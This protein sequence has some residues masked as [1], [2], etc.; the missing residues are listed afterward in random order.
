MAVSSRE[1]YIDGKRV[2][3]APA[4]L[5]GQGGEAEVY[6]LGDG[7]VLKWWKPV[8]H[9]DF[10]GLPDAQAA[11]ARRLAEQ[12]AKLRALPGNL[13]AAVVT[14]CGLALDRKQAVVGY[15]MTKVTGEPLHAYGEPRWRRDHAI[16]G[17]DVVAILVAL[18]DALAGLHRAGVVVGDCN[19]L[20]V[21]VDGNRVH[22]IDVDSYQYGG[23][24]CP[25][26]SE[27]FL[28][29]RLVAANGA[30]APHDRDSDWFAF[31]VMTLR[32][33]L[34]VGP[35]GG[36][37]QPSNPT[38]R[39]PPPARAQRRISVFAPDIIYPRAARPVA[40][41][42][43]AMLEPLR[44]IFESDRRGEF[45]RALLE[46]LRLRD[47]SACGEEHGRV[48]CPACQAQAYVPPVRVH[49]NL[50]WQP[51][52]ADAVAFPYAVTRTTPVWLDAGALWRTTRLGPER[53]GG[54]L[55]GLTHAWVG[56]KLGVGFYRAGGYAVGFVFRPD[57]GGLD[58]GVALPK[59]RG[60]LISAHATLADDR[61]W[62]WLTTADQGRIATTCIVI[63][64]D[65]RVIASETLADAP[66]LAGVA[67]ACAAG[68]HLFVPTD[69]GLARIEVI[70]GAI[71]QTRVFAETA[72]LVS[73]GD[74]LSL[75]TGGIDAVR[76]RDAIRMQLA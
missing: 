28:D 39:C 36:V 53:I 23:F 11:A 3:L 22:L 33:L 73:S 8:D 48:K 57:R 75:T 63:G 52:A 61:A 59:I 47:C 44:A 37:H 49:G 6:D 74:R 25:M 14:P 50:R 55:A 58:D 26:F 41:L 38:L 12:P 70:Q 42:P 24:T 45:P 4:Q 20:N 54:V 68:P 71:T 31:A 32:S 65:A 18:H 34:G 17:A 35:W 15:L 1:V 66:W 30:L 72:A 69:D 56:P 21:L 62:L 19:D 2:R 9:P 10:D 60:Q 5:V 7:R 13:P 67:G 29:P 40:I 64:G 27:R 16:R 76:R 46:R 51:I 43:D